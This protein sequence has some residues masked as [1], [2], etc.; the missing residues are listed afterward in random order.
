M[1]VFNDIDWTTR[2]YSERWISNSEQVK[3]CAKKLSQGHWTF[4]GLGSEKT[5]GMDLEVGQFGI[6][7]LVESWGKRTRRPFISLRMPSTQ[8][9]YIERFT[10]EIS[11][12]STEQSQA[13]VESSLNGLRMKKSRLWRGSQQKKTSSHWKMRNRKKWI[14]CDPKHAENTHFLAKILIPESMQRFQ[15]KQK[16]EPSSSSSYHTISWHQRN[17]NSDSFHNNERANLLGGDKPR[18]KTAMWSSCISMIQTTI[19]QVLNCWWKDLFCSSAKMEPSSSIEETHAMQ[20]EIQTNPVCNCS[21]TEMTFLPTNISEDILFEAEVLKIGHEIP[22]DQ[23]E[24]G[25]DGAV[26]WNSMGPKQWEAFHKAGGQKLS[27]ADWLQYIHEATKRGS[28]TARIP[29][30]CHCKFVLFKDTLV[31]TWWRL[32]RWVTSLFYTMLLW[33]ANPQIRTHRWRTRKQ[34]RKTYHLLHTSQSRREQSWRRTTWRWP[35]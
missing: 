20:F 6:R 2:G 35:L 7:W 15:D 32:S 5:N 28:R 9:S 1:S 21:G 10:L 34:R 27:N 30:M 3:N 24:R 13:G 14:L 11:S 17:W 4:L 16:I 25:T 31:G 33:R 12:V 18:E 23:D 26:H 19:P 29:G 8:S 22:Y